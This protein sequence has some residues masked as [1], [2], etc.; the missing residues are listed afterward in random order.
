M[1]NHSLVPDIIKFFGISFGSVSRASG[2]ISKAT[3]FRIGTGRLPSAS[4]EQLHWFS[5]GLALCI[6]EKCKAGRV[7][8]ISRADVRSLEVNSTQ[9]E[10]G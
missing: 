5:V 4:P 7:F 2:N 10:V 6:A 9:Q 1:S 8:P 3:A